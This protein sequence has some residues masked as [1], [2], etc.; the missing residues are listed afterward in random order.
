MPQAPNRLPPQASEH[1]YQRATVD[2]DW[3]EVI[4]PWTV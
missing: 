3:G 2:K 4:P 1:H